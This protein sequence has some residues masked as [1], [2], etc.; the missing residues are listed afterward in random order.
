M[1]SGKKDVRLTRFD[2]QELIGY[3][4]DG[5]GK[6]TAKVFEGK[7]VFTDGSSRI[8]YGIYEEGADSIKWNYSPNQIKPHIDTDEMGIKIKKK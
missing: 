1:T 2:Y 5:S 8:L 4:T 6:I 3:Q 7:G